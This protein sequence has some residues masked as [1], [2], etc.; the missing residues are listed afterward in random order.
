MSTRNVKDHLAD[1]MAITDLCNRYTDAVN[2]RSARDIAAVFAKDGVWDC[3]G[4]NAG[5]MCFLFTGNQEIGNRIAEMLGAMEVL[6]QTNHA[7]VIEVNGDR[8]TARS[9]V[10]EKGLP[11]GAPTGM[12]AMGTYTDEIVRDSDGEWRFAKRTFRFTYVD[13]P[14]MNGQVMATFPAA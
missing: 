4:P 6:V 3:G 1:H 9:T 13:G 5:P 2:R 7:L 10:E 11:K 8:A 12:R 14:A